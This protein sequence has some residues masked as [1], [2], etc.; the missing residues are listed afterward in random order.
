MTFLSSRV[1]RDKYFSHCSCIKFPVLKKKKLNQEHSATVNHR[2]K[3]ASRL[4][5]HFFSPLLSSLIH[6]PRVFWPGKLL[7]VPKRSMRI[8]KGR[9]HL[10]CAVPKISYVGIVDLEPSVTI[11]VQENGTAVHHDKKDYRI[12]ENHDEGRQKYH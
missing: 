11:N 10:L 8:K 6:Y 3:T 1:R 9:Y 4:N 5:L 7:T 12:N 2:V